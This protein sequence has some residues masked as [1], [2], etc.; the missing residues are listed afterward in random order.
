MCWLPLSDKTN[1]VA[2][3]NASQFKDCANHGELGH[4]IQNFPKLVPRNI[5]VDAKYMRENF[6]TGGFR[7]E[8]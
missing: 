8:F 4:R 1:T 5:Q 7:A 2:F 6:G 3:G